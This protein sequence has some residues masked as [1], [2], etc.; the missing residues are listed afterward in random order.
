MPE[1]DLSLLKPR[2][3]SSL[4]PRVPVRYQNVHYDTSRELLCSDLTMGRAQDSILSSFSSSILALNK[5]PNELS[6][7]GMI[8]KAFV[9]ILHRTQNWSP[10]ESS[11][12]FL[13][14]E[15]HHG[16]RSHCYRV[17]RDGLRRY[18]NEWRFD[19]D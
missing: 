7:E 9:L 6:L 17:Q 12:L 15:E 13:C 5:N 16:E 1:I 8:P 11:R 4:S 19:N 2:K 10:S 14:M 18:Y 3:R